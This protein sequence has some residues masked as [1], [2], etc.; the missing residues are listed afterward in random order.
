MLA[1]QVMLAQQR[2]VGVLRI[3]HHAFSGHR[4]K[5]TGDD[6]NRAPKQ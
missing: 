1:Q 3:T 4:E 2:S 5:G 6:G